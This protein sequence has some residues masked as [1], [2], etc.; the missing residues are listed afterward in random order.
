[1]TL[2]YAGVEAHIGPQRFDSPHM[3]QD[4]LRLLPNIAAK[5]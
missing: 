5:V 3:D 4:D 1:M 2:S